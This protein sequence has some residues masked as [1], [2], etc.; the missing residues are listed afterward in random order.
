[1]IAISYCT[2]GEHLTRDKH[3]A[4]IQQNGFAGRR[5]SSCRFHGAKVGPLVLLDLHSG[6]LDVFFAVLAPLG[7]VNNKVG[8]LYSHIHR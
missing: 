5:G 4:N 7:F 3:D 1:M 8:H 6:S 2:A